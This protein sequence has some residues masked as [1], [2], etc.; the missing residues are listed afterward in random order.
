MYEINEYSYKGSK[1]KG[2]KVFK[3]EKHCDQRGSVVETYRADFFNDFPKFVQDNQ[4]ISVTGVLRGLHFQRKH[5]QGKLIKVLDGH[6]NDVCVDLR[7]KSPTFLNWFMISIDDSYMVW[8]PH[9]FAH[10]FIAIKKSFVLYKCTDYYYPDDQYGIIW[11]DM[12]LNID[13]EI[14]NLKPL[15]SLKDQ[16]LPTL[17]EICQG[18]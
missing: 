11:N 9:G 12:S 4:S 7:K 6:I 8:I 14:K 1:L 17:E 16:K 15:L 18:L 13:W 3:L 5:Q 2:V 10:G